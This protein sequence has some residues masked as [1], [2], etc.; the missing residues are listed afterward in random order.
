VQ[1][2]SGDV[3]PCVLVLV[4]SASTIPTEREHEGPGMSGDEPQFFLLATDDMARFDEMVSIYQEAIIPSEQK[5]P[6]ELAKMLRSPSYRVVLGSIAGRIVGVA[7]SFFSV[8]SRFWLLEYMAV[9]RNLRSRGLGRD[10]FFA[11]RRDAA[12]VAGAFP[13]VLEVDQPAVPAAANSDQ[14]RRLR[15]YARSGCRRI[16]GLNYIMPLDVAGTPPPMWLLVQGLDDREAVSTSDVAGWLTT[17][18]VEVY[19]QQPDDPRLSQMLSYA[20]DVPE[21]KL[22][23]LA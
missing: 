18:Y 20:Q 2:S 23:P 17:I 15:F 10:L 9:D 7:I 16:E 6:S 5:A 8:R 1:G 11:A 14:S 4:A 3:P 22:E 21:L 19:G 13:C 12:A